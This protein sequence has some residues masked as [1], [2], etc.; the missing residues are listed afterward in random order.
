[1]RFE[2]IARPLWIRRTAF[3]RRASFWR[4]TRRFE[5]GRCRS[6]DT[7]GAAPFGSSARLTINTCRVTMHRKQLGQMFTCADPAQSPRAFGSNAVLTV[8]LAQASHARP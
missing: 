2:K 7:G 6:F 8:G 3:K 5:R 1:Q 4:R